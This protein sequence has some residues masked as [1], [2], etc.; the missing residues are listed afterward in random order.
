MVENL[1]YLPGI[2]LSDHLALSFDMRL[3]TEEPNLQPKLRLHKG[4]Y[5]SMNAQLGLIDWTSEL[6]GKNAKESWTIF[7]DHFNTAMEDHIP[8]GIPRK[9]KKKKLW[10]TLWEAMTTM[11]S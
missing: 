4:D 11:I 6:S 3:Y 10:M 7:S 5:N 2:G 8:K 1:R 9:R